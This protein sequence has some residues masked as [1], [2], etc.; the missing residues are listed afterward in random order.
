MTIVMWIRV[1]TYKACLHDAGR[2]EAYIKLQLDS[3]EVVE[4]EPDDDVDRDIHLYPGKD[5]QLQRYMNA[6][7]GI[8]DLSL[9]AAISAPTDWPA[10]QCASVHVE[11]LTCTS[12]S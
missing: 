3:S 1:H 6:E 5:L 10:V 9:W 12:V 8:V 4:C 11:V 7:L 2:V